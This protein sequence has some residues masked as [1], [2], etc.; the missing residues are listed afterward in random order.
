M[1]RVVSEST[2]T[3]SHRK[4]GF[5]CKHMYLF[6]LK[7]QARRG[8][9][10]QGGALLLPTGAKLQRRK[11]NPAGCRAILQPW[12][13]ALSGE[14]PLA[15]T[16]LQ[17]APDLCVTA[18]HAGVLSQAPPAPSTVPP[19]RENLLGAPPSREPLASQDVFGF[20]LLP[21]EEGEGPATCTDPHPFPKPSF[22]ALQPPRA[23]GT[24]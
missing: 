6:V 5:T 21:Q 9:A 1:L 22:Q 20:P 19:E 12:G 11:C 24:R 16:M 2:D 4:G 23:A 15:R 17:E 8:T 3:C 13:W 14:G 18:S 7:Q 10:L